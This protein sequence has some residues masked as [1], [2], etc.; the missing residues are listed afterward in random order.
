MTLQHVTFEVTPEQV[1]AHVAFWGILGYAL[2]ET[3]APLHGRAVWMRRGGC[4]VHLLL[5]DAPVV[6]P[7]AHVAL[8]VENWEATLAALARAG[9]EATPAMRLWD[10]ER[11]Y[12]RAPGGHR[13]EI[14]TAGP[15]SARSTD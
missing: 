1:E 14:M 15:V 3:P 8:I 2:I 12:L 7:R 4:D 11:V 6:P 9:Y 13:V 10:A 5:D